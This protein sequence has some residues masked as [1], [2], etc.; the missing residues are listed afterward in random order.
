MYAVNLNL[1]FRGHHRPFFQKL[2]FSAPSLSQACIQF[3]FN[4][5]S[6]VHARLMCLLLTQGFND[7][8]VFRPYYEGRIIRNFLFS[9]FLTKHTGSLI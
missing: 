8:N 5:F 6:C 7:L 1:N 2:F 3:C 9:A 4:T